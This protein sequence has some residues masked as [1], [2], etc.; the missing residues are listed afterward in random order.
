[1]PLPNPA[2]YDVEGPN[3]AVWLERDTANASAPWATASGSPVSLYFGVQDYILAFMDHNGRS[4][5]YPYPP[6][7]GFTGTISSPL[8]PDAPRGAT[9]FLRDGILGPATLAMIWQMLNGQAALQSAVLSDLRNRRISKGTMEIIVALQ[10]PDKTINIATSAIM[11]PFDRRI[12]G[13]PAAPTVSESVTPVGVTE[14]GPSLCA[15]PSHV[16]AVPTD[17]DMIAGPQAPQYD[18]QHNVIGNWN[19][20]AEY[21][22]WVLAHASCARPPLYCTPLPYPPRGVTQAEYDQYVAANPGCTPPILAVTPTSTP[23]RGQVV[24]AASQQAPAPATPRAM[25]RWA[26]AT[27]GVAGVGVVGYLAYRSMHHPPSAPPPARP[28]QNP[29]GGE[30]PPPPSGGFPWVGVLGTAAVIGVG[31]VLLARRNNRASAPIPATVTQ[32]AG[33]N[34]SGPQMLPEVAPP[35]PSPMPRTTSPATSAPVP[36]PQPQAPVQPP[37]AP[38]PVPAPT[39]DRSDHLSVAEVF[40]FKTLTYAQQLAWVQAHPSL[41][42]PI[43]TDNERI[44]YMLLESERLMDA[45]KTTT[46]QA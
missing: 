20:R 34:A 18:A 5:T 27:A 9:V 45:Q 7:S 44:G 36:A 39:A 33:A 2:R 31:G 29:A 19:N 41:F 10:R 14:S 26:L 42:P 35:P 13:A 16:T 40:R 15:L 32:Q 1:M 22:A 25:P 6:N 21:D 38:A 12:A 30:V 8:N 43:L 23:D 17:S 37:P 3:N 46:A 11:P 28:R 4:Q 24:P